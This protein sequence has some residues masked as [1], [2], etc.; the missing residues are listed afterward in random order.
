MAKQRNQELIKLIHHCD[1]LRAA[2]DRARQD[3]HEMIGEAGC[4]DFCDCVHEALD[5]GEN[6][7]ARLSEAQLLQ[8]EFIDRKNTK[9]ADEVTR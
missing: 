6:M 2:F 4:C 3:C 9:T 1:Q 5:S 8:K 7:L